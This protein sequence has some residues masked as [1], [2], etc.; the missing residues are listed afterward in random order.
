MFIFTEAHTFGRGL[1]RGGYGTYV[2]IR[3]G[4]QTRGNSQLEI[5]ANARASTSDSRTAGQ[6]RMSIGS[7]PGGSASSYGGIEVGSRRRGAF[8]K[9]YLGVNTQEG[10]LVRGSNVGLTNSLHG[11]SH[12]KLVIAAETYTP[13][14]ASDGSLQGETYTNLQGASSK[15]TG[16][17]VGKGNG[18]AIGVGEF[19]SRG[20]RYGGFRDSVQGGFVFDAN[21]RFR[22]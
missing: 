20:G 15:L 2:T 8:A 18:Q 11:A 14:S 13:G 19:G 16:Q 6:Q 17:G 9:S 22:H 5:A 12:G 7:I 3:S 4:G 1:G 10:G 21:T